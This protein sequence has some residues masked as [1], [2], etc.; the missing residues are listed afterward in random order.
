[1][2]HK[3]DYEKNININKI[4]LLVV[5]NLFILIQIHKIFYQR[6]GYLAPK[7]TK[8]NSIFPKLEQVPRKFVIPKITFSICKE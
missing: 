4:A 1:M 5:H 8:I 6:L 2:M 3:S 7:S